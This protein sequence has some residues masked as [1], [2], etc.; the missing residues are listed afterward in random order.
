MYQFK[1]PDLGEGIAEA[2]MVEWHVKEGDMVQE[3]QLIGE[4]MTDKAVMEIPSP[5]SGRVHRLCAVE[6]GVSPRSTGNTSPYT[7]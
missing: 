3:N 5:K 6:G 7:L 4:V 2:E 1:L